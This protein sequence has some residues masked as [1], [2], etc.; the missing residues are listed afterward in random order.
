[1]T[2]RSS[3][4]IL[5]RLRSNRLEGQGGRILRNALLR[6]FLRMRPINVDGNTQVS[7]L[8]VDHGLLQLGDLLRR[9]EA[10]GAG[11]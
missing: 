4:L 5:R 7:N 1:M 6:A 3:A 10:L 9:V 8:S 11:L 2:E